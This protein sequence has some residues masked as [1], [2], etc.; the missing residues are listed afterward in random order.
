MHFLCL[1]LFLFLNFY[2]FCFRVLGLCGRLPSM[3]GHSRL[4]AGNIL[5]S[6]RRLHTT[7][8]CPV[9][10]AVEPILP[11]PSRQPH[12]GRIS[13]TCDT[14]LPAL[15]LRAITPF[16]WAPVRVTATFQNPFF[17]YFLYP[18]ADCDPSLSPVHAFSPRILNL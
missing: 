16:L 8:H 12:F 10:I 1:F 17:D 15:L 13:T 14:L 3:S 4:L 6:A 11:R 7:K 9:A 2:A 5:P 18:S